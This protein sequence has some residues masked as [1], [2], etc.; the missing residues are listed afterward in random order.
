[1]DVTV[2]SNIASTLR[3]LAPLQVLQRGLPRP[4]N[5]SVYLDTYA[6]STSQSAS[7]IEAAEALVQQEMLALL[8]HEAVKYP[9]KERK[10][11]K[12]KRGAPEVDAP[13]GP[14]EKWEDIPVRPAF[15]S[16]APLTGRS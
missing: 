7:A 6:P 12:R 14:L 8:Q 10:K 9:N 5:L 15:E 16:S 3:V 11:G 1:M 4:D 2:I 13:V